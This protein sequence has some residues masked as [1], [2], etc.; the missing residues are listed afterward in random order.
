MVGFGLDFTTGR[1]QTGSANTT[2]DIYYKV[3]GSENGRSLTL[4]LTY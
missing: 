2:L 1:V 3:C 4:T